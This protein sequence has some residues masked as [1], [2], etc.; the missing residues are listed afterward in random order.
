MTKTINLNAM[1]LMALTRDEL[2][3]CVFFRIYVALILIFNVNY[4]LN[5]SLCFHH[6]Y[7]VEQWSIIYDVWIHIFWMWH[8]N[9]FTNLIVNVCLTNEWVC[10]LKMKKKIK[11]IIPTT[12]QRCYWPVSQV[13]KEIHRESTRK[14]RHD[15]NMLIKLN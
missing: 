2:F 8:L 10:H 4:S 11:K 6:M 9:A 1:I 15:N 13:E 12:Q 3:M 7:Y 5:T 14:K